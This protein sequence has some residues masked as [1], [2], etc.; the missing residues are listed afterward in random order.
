M[1]IKQKIKIGLV[2]AS[3]ITSSGCT[4]LGATAFKAPDYYVKNVAVQQTD[5]QQW[6]SVDELPLKARNFSV[7]T[8]TYPKHYYFEGF[9]QKNSY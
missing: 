1:Y 2:C 6:Q 9:L 8:D 5:F 3:L 4:Q 7:R